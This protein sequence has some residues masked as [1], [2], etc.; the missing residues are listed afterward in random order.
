[1]YGPDNRLILSFDNGWR[2][3]RS[4]KSGGFNYPKPDEVEKLGFSG[5]WF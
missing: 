1:M 2:T 3:G 5:G 4:V